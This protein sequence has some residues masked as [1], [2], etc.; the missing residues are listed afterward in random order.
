[1]GEARAQPGSPPQ[2]VSISTDLAA[3]LQERRLTVVTA[4]PITTWPSDGRPSAFRLE[5]D[6][7]SVLK[8][9]QFPSVQRAH[10]FER[11]LQ[12]TLSGFP[13]PIARH[14]CA[15]LL[16]W[17]EGDV[18]ASLD[19]IPLDVIHRCGANL[20]ALHRQ[21][22]SGWPDVVVRQAD[23][24]LARLRSDTTI[25]VEAGELEKDAAAG[26]HALA[27]E[28]APGTASAGIIHNDFC[29]E[30]IVLDA[31]GTPVCV[32]NATLTFGPH[33]YDLARSWYRWPMSPGE[34]EAFLHGYETHRSGASFEHHFVF[35]AICMLTA[36]AA[37]RLRMGIGD[38]AKSLDAL[39]SILA[40]FERG[41]PV[42][43][44]KARQTEGG[45]QH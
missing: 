25:L 14:G 15:L 20:G 5:L 21:D 1:M 34:S 17:I 35:W 28:H 26:A 18:L 29:S 7:G 36:T 22:V 4:Q 41:E 11:I 38:H 32:D 30:N 40:A 6:D 8:A 2:A 37:N 31:S 33:D 3:L 24:V 27:N 44:W 16:P 13:Q 9:R 19:S 10:T 42:R 43:P 39:R 12:M 45:S 23:E